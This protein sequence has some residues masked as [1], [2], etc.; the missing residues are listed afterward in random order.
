MDTTRI[1]EV[2]DAAADRT[3]II[4]YNSTTFPMN[5]GCGWRPC[6]SIVDCITLTRAP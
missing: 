4:S 3:T 2:T 1:S 5:Q 6:L